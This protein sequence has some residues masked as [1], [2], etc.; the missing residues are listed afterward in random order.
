MFLVSFPTL[1]VTVITL[2]TSRATVITPR[3]SHTCVCG[4]GLSQ[5]DREREREGFGKSILGSA[6]YNEACLRKS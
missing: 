3:T 6:R 4:W 1:S 2:R 5:R